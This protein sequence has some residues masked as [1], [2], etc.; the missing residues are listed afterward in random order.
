MLLNVIFLCSFSLYKIAKKGELLMT[1]EEAIRLII[2][3][4]EVSKC[5][6][7]ELYLSYR[8]HDKLQDLYVLLHDLD[9]EEHNDKQQNK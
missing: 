9:L 1:K 3:K 6:A 8:K 7:S 5:V 2:K 4:F